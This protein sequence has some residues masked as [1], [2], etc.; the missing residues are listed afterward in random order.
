MIELPAPHTPAIK[1]AT[2]WQDRIHRS[3]NKDAP[4]DWAIERV[5][6]THHG[7]SSVVFITNTAESDF[8]AHTALSCV[9]RA[10]HFIF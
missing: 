7:L 4:F 9:I 6:A 5:G 1:K 3:L 2:S 8:G 10:W